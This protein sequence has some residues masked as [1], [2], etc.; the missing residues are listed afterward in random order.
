MKKLS[1]VK[2]GGASLAEKEGRRKAAAH[3]KRLLDEYKKLVVVVSAM[4]RLDDAYAT[5]TLLG[6]ASSPMPREKIP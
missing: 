3:C 1:V 6:L 2:F 5:D 4:G